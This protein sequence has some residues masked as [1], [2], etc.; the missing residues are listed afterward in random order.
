M[1]Y[2]IDDP[3][4]DKSQFTPFAVVGGDH[5]IHAWKQPDPETRIMSSVHVLLQ[6]IQAARA[7]DVP[8]II[9]GD[10]THDKNN[11]N[12]VVTS[13]LMDLFTQEKANGSRIILNVGNHERTEKYHNLHTL[14][15]FEPVVDLIASEPHLIRLERHGSSLKLN[16]MLVPF[17]Y[18]HKQAMV[19]IDLHKLWE[20]VPT[21]ETLVFVGHYPVDGAEVNGVK[22]HF[23]IKLEDFRPAQFEALL[24][25]DIHKAQPV[26]EKAYHLGCTHQNTFGEEGYKY[27]WWALGLWGNDPTAV[28]IARLP[29]TAPEFYTVEQRYETP[30]NDY[31]REKPATVIA[32]SLEEQGAP[33]I[34]LSNASLGE[35]I[36]RYLTYQVNQGLL[37]QDRKAKILR[38]V[39]E[40]LR[41]AN[42]PGAR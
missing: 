20:Q 15:C 41:P 18:N 19:D 4:A 40:I 35:S 13:E 22:P 37:V 2:V 12:P 26:S 31:M 33:R 6:G 3:T 14:K 39:M 11:L 30:G 7:M 8:L 21:G 10:L 29:T 38:A 28:T 23:G 36:E 34:Q 32:R 1:L 27:G 5:H 42:A 25:N 16:V 24:F 9:N 17:Y